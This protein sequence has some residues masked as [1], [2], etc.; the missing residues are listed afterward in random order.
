MSPVNMCWWHGHN[1]SQVDQLTILKNV[2]VWLMKSQSHQQPAPWAIRAMGAAARPAVWTPQG[3]CEVQGDKQMVG[4]CVTSSPCSSR[5]FFVLLASPFQ[6]SA[7]LWTILNPTLQKD[8]AGCFE[9]S[10]EHRCVRESLQVSDI[11]RACRVSRRSETLWNQ[12]ERLARSF[13]HKVRPNSSGSAKIPVT[14]PGSWRQ[15]LGMIMRNHGVFS[16][17]ASFTCSV[18][19]GTKI[20]MNDVVSIYILFVF[21]RCILNGSFTL[22][23]RCFN[24]HDSGQII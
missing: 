23:F 6:N 1:R 21:V 7:V 2:T 8:L 22:D 3:S 13:Q 20:I 24:Y 18:F 16:F 15:I 4:I 17:V 9:D 5:C 10:C 12:A 14:C 19:F 11:D